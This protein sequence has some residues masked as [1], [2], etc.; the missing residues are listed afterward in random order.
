MRKGMFIVI[1]GGDRSDDRHIWSVKL[2]STGLEVSYGILKTS[3]R[4]QE[5]PVVII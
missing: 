3:D 2:N 1:L 4:H 5:S